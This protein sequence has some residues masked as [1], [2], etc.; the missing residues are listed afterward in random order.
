M[1]VY[2]SPT[3]HPTSPAAPLPGGHRGHPGRRC[4][5]DIRQPQLTRE[6]R[7]LFGKCITATAT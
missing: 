1:Y 3:G 2:M 7:K 4:T 6:K 5:C